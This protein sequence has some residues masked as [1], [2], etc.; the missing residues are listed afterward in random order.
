MLRW[1]VG[2]LV[3]RRV[4]DESFFIGGGQR[5]FTDGAHEAIR[6]GAFLLALIAIGRLL[7]DGEADAQGD[8]ASR[9]QS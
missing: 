4:V 1:L 9:V 6:A 3:R 8:R 2:W 7:V 5:P